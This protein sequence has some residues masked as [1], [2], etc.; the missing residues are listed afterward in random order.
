MTFQ[1]WASAPSQL[2]TKPDNLK[3]F[4]LWYK[5]RLTLYLYSEDQPPAAVSAVATTSPGPAKPQLFG[6]KNAA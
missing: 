3:N 5:E 6:Q 4:L 2:K 1:S